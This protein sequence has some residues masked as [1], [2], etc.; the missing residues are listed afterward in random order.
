MS[1]ETLNNLNYNITFNEN[2]LGFEIKKVLSG[3]AI[4]SFVNTTLLSKTY[5]GE[6]IDVASISAFGLD[7]LSLSMG[8]TLL[9][10]TFQ[11]SNN[12]KMLALI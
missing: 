3:L 1:S 12:S 2:N 6:T 10:A 5:D 11:I 4:I 7:N 9:S 8:A